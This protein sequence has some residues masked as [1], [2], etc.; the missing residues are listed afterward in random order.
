MS[1]T[2]RHLANWYLYALGLGY[3]EMEALR[4]VQRMYPKGSIDM[5]DRVFSWQTWPRVYW[6]EVKWDAVHYGWPASL[7][8]ELDKCATVA[9]T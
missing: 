2:D 8:Q 3:G 4:A 9:H 5:G 7:K 6:D 1:T